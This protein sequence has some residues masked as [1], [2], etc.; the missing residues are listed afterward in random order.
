MFKWKLVWPIFIPIALWFALIGIASPSGPPPLPLAVASSIGMVIGICV[1][2]IYPQKVL[3]R[4]VQSFLGQHDFT[5][6]Q[7]HEVEPE[8][9]ALYRSKGSTKLGRSEI[10]DLFLGEWNG[11]R[12]VLGQHLASSE[13][14][15]AVFTSCAVELFAESP[16]LRIKPKSKLDSKS[17]YCPLYDD[18]FDRER[19]FT[20][21]D[22][23]QGRSILLPLV[24]WFITNR[25][26]LDAFAYNWADDE[27]WIISGTWLIFAQRG[28]TNGP[29]WI[30]LAK[31]TTTFADEYDLRLDEVNQTQSEH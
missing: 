13:T 4:K 7:S 26:R 22:I 2:Y 17:E 11:R 6:L 3:Y 9:A 24:D 20:C 1:C 31:F 16:S 30:Q 21:E 18:R 14:S 8:L 10:G 5:V 23:N 19:A 27:T 28:Q 12:V 25:N 15:L 29:M